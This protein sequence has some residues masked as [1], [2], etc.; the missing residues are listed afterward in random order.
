[1]GLVRRR[2]RFPGASLHEL[3][4]RESNVATGLVQTATDI[5]FEI[6]RGAHRVILRVT[7]NQ[8]YT[9][10][11]PVPTHE[12]TVVFIIMQDEPGTGSYTV[13]TR[14]GATSFVFDI[15]RSRT[16]ISNAS[17]SYNEIAAQPGQTGSPGGSDPG[18]STIGTVATSTPTDLPDPVG[19]VRTLEAN[20]A[21]IVQGS[22][23]I[24]SDRLVCSDGTSIVGWGPNTSSLITAGSVLIQGSCEIRNIRLQA[25]LGTAIVADSADDLYLHNVL[26]TNC[27]QAVDVQLCDLLL[28]DTVTVNN[29][30]QGIVITGDAPTANLTMVTVVGSGGSYRAFQVTDTGDVG[31]SVISKSTFDADGSGAFSLFFDPGARY[32]VIRVVENNTRVTNGAVSLGGLPNTDPLFI[33]R[34]NLGI[35]DSQF[36]GAYGF[37]GNTVET[38]ISASATFVNI[39]AG[40]V[41]H[42]AKVADPNIERFS[43][44]GTNPDE[45]ITFIGQSPIETML[46]FSISTTR[47]GGG[48][49]THGFQVL[50]NDVVVT[51]PTASG[52]ID[53]GVLPGTTASQSRTIPIRLAPSDR[54]RLQISNENDISNIVVTDFL[55]MAW[56]VG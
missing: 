22:V 42:P 1:M 35:E 4:A 30:I 25:P 23:D 32:D 41:G 11:F 15:V 37:S 5:D 17:G 8:D 18:S 27:T 43:V 48:S 39:G 10:T 54:L 51:T 49:D 9:A 28:F 53:A 46:S 14:D 55:M 19:G 3:N 33:Y 44:T 31:P 45:E 6:E 21:Y 26:I 29:S 40:G 16:F 52:F 50:L 2:E 47:V 34:D 7:D 20:T 38:V 56:R 36:L 24:G 13:V 12:G